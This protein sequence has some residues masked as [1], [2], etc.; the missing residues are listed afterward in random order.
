MRQHQ[1]MLVLPYPGG[2]HPRIGFLVGAI[3]PQRETKFSI[4]CPWDAYS[5]VVADVPEAIWSNLGLTYLAHTHVPTIWDKQG[6]TLPI[7]EWT[8]KANGRLESERTL[9]NGIKFRV[10][11]KPT[12][13]ALR[14]EMSLTNGTDQ[15]LTDLRVQ[16][17]FMLKMCEGF[18]QQTNDNKKFVKPYAVAHDIDRKRWIIAGWSPI[19]R[20]WGNAPCPCLHADP[21]FPDC[22]PGETKTIR[23]WFSVY[24]GSD[25]NAELNR[26]NQLDWMNTAL[27]T[28]LKSD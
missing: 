21:K 17:C 20:V 25:I 10:I 11:V 5:Y 26:L 7:Q 16:Q 24:Q 28:E 27:D 6:K 12:A 2:R 18:A 1:R 19:Q 3:D 14:M 23:G 13:K 4:F 9:P 8:R 22:P 15:P